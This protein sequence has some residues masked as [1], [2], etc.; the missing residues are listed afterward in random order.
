LPSVFTP[1]NDGSN[2]IFHP[3]DETTTSELQ[4]KNCPPYKNVKSVEMKIY[5]RW[6][7]LVFETTDKDVNWDGKNKDS[8]G[9]CPEGVYY[10]TCKVFFFRI[11]GDEAVELHGTVQ[12][13]R[14]N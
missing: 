14:G 1:N 10:Y 2:D 12:L 4:Q 3:C 8:K 7:N 5:N 6:G 13:I 9:D 11:S